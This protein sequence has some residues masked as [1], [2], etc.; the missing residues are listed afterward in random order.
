LLKK[1]LC[2][3]GIE[4]TAAREEWSRAT[5]SRRGGEGGGAWWEHF[6]LKFFK[7]Q[8]KYSHH[9]SFKKITQ[10]ISS[11]SQKKE[12]KFINFAKK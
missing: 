1:G 7:F 3:A 8:K 4:L 11:I 12:K 2:H 10:N 9:A 6:C 5:P